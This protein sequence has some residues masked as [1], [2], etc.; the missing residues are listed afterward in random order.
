MFKKETYINRRN[1]LKSKLKTGIVL[2]PGN[3]ESSMSY[4]ANTYHFRQDSNFLYFFG[5][6]Q[7]HLIGLIDIDNDTDYI[8]GDD[9]EIDDIIWMGQQPSVASLANKVGIENTN[10]YSTIYEFIKKVHTRKI[11]FLPTYRGEQK[12]FY[13][14]LLGIHP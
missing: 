12:I 3:E 14:N 5:L 2:I 4:P 11:H 1:A 8:F 13:Q 7:P 9:V 10:K 6:N